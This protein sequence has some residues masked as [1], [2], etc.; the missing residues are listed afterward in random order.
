MLPSGPSILRP[1]R[2]WNRPR[3][4]ASSLPEN[5]NPNQRL[6]ASFA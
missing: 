2:C 1:V 6:S 4:T 3:V 5:S